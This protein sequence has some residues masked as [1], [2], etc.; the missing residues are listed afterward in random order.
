[1]DCVSIH[2]YLTRYIV[3]YL[4]LSCGGEVKRLG[5]DL[6]RKSSSTGDQASGGKTS[7]ELHVE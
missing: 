7:E 6:L 5:V 1:V 2:S 3:T 4:G